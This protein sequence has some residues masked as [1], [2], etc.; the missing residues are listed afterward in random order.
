MWLRDQ[1]QRKPLLRLWS[2]NTP[3]E[4]TCPHVLCWAQ[5]FPCLPWHS[6]GNLGPEFKMQWDIL[7]QNLT[8]KVTPV[9][10]LLPPSLP[11]TSCLRHSFIPL[12]LTFFFFKIL[13]F[14]LFKIPD[15]WTYS[16]AKLNK[17]ESMI[18]LLPFHVLLISRFTSL[19]RSLAWTLLHGHKQTGLMPPLPP[20]DTLRL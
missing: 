19:K 13:S 1:Q 5:K 8:Y 6:C 17:M 4:V 12:P 15:H 7:S 9:S 18:S 20:N 11:H 16:W 2:G 3:E 14:F 10:I